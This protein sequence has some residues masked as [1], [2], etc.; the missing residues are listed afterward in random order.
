MRT[1]AETRKELIDTKF[2][3]AG[4]DRTVFY[5]YPSPGNSRRRRKNVGE[6]VGKTTQETTQ[7]KALQKA[8]GGMNGGLNGGLKLFRIIREFK[9]TKKVNALVSYQLNTALMGEL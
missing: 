9:L 4:S 1:E 8:D 7:E 3:A 2:Y 6:N 5:H